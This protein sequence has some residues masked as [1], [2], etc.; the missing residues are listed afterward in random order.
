MNHFLY[1]EGLLPTREPFKQLL[2][3]GMV[4]G[5]SYRVKNTGKYLR[6]DQVEQIGKNK[7]VDKESRNPVACTWEKMS[8]SKYNG[9]DPLDMFAQYGT[10]TTRLIILADVAPTS[11]RNWSSVCKLTYITVIKIRKV[12]HLVAGNS[13]VL[14]SHFQHSLALS[15]GSIDCG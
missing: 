7:F 3:Q 6:E 9:V 12:R 2:V 4:M 1:S 10:D 5:R 15:N 14:F 13:L 8:K 11:H